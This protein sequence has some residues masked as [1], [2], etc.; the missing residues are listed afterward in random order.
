[1]PTYRTDEK[2]YVVAFRESQPPSVEGR[3]LEGSDA[4]A[5]AHKL[6]H[7]PDHCDVIE[8]WVV[9]TETDDM[10]LSWSERD[11]L[12]IDRSGSELPTMN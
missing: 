6:A 10:Q 1:M 12:Y 3:D 8:V 2:F 7:H 4:V 5:L 9:E 11:G